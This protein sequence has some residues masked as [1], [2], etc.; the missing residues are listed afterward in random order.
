[1]GGGV[2][3]SDYRGNVRII[4]T[5]LSNKAK[6]IETGD[7]TVQ[8]LFIKKEDVEFE[9]VNEFDQTERGTIGFGSTGK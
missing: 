8:V 9:E 5:N 4:L 3:D 1:M 7:R 2:V 6:E